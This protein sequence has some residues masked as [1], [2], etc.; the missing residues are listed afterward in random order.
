MVSSK[1]K[2]NVWQDKRRARLDQTESIDQR[3][4]GDSSG[5]KTRRDT[6]Q[7][8]RAA[9]EQF[10]PARI[11]KRLLYVLYYIYVVIYIYIYC[12]YMYIYIV[13]Y[14]YMYIF[15]IL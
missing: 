6:P 14:M 15:Y 1:V 13:T 3:K 8:Q 2:E 12:V 9:R 5:D 7:M 10:P 4:K 11:L